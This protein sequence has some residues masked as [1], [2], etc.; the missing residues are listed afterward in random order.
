[1]KFLE[2]GA[3]ARG[4]GPYF[5]Q[6]PQMEAEMLLCRDLHF[7]GSEYRKIHLRYVKEKSQPI[8]IPLRP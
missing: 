8:L 1:M 5:A 3:R 2:Y 7:V 4:A 6:N